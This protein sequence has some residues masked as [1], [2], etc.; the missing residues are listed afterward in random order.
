ML[1]MLLCVFSTS[2]FS[3]QIFI[4]NGAQIF[5]DKKATVTP[6]LSESKKTDSTYIYIVEGTT[7][8]GLESNP[9]IAVK[10]INKPENTKIRLAKNLAKEEKE[11]E[12]PKSKKKKYIPQ[13]KFITKNISEGKFSFSLNQYTVVASA[14]H[15]N[16]KFF[17]L[18][19]TAEL[20]TMLVDEIEL[21][22]CLSYQYVFAILLNTYNVRPPPVIA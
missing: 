18:F 11:V 1:F 14:N 20:P 3:A 15:Q 22:T 12:E 10:Y 17:A 9:N 6:N 21:Q 7:V 2:Y 13:K 19:S 8:T 4:S 16:T 5:I